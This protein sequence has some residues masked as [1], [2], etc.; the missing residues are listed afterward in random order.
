MAIE[1]VKHW[2]WG[3]VGTFLLS[4]LSTYGPETVRHICLFGAWVVASITFYYTPFA[5][6]RLHVSIPVAV[7]FAVFF[8]Y[9]IW[10]PIATNFLAKGWEYSSSS[11]KSYPVYSDFQDAFQDHPEL[12]AATSN[13]GPTKVSVIW[14]DNALV[15]WVE[16]IN[17]TPAHIA[18]DQSSQSHWEKIPWLP[19]MKPPN[20][21]SD[22]KYLRRKHPDTPVNRHPLFSGLS[23]MRYTSRPQL[24]WVGSLVSG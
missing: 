9:E 1:K 24:E 10:I 22:E 16:D 14:T 20:E 21:L 5:S 11:I 13:G 12:G 2:G 23:L 4:A 7:L 15:I 8:G 19:S 3:L 18:I 17:G 6:R